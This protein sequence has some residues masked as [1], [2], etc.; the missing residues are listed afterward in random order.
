MSAPKRI[1][2]AG[3]TFERIDEW[4]IRMSAPSGDTWILRYSNDRYGFARFI[5]DFAEAAADQ[6]KGSEL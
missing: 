4:E 1:S 6:K 3:Y 5:W 2:V